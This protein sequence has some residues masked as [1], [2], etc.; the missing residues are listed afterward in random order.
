MDETEGFLKKKIISVSNEELSPAGPRKT[1]I[2]VED[3]I[4]RAKR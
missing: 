3:Q 4:Q 2:Q 1:D